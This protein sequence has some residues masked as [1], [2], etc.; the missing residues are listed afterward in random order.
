MSRE[1]I[2]ERTRQHLDVLEAAGLV[3]TEKIGRVRICAIEPHALDL[4]EQWI[5][6]PRT[7]WEQRLDRLEVYLKTFD[8][9]GDD[10]DTDA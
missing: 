5:T 6:A 10:D 3:R 9:N 2:A 8:D 4:A 1:A 7:E